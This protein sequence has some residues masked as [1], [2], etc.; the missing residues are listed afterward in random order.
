[1]LFESD[2][3]IGPGIRKGIDPKNG[4]ESVRLGIVMN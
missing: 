1:M 4:F 3:L 2:W